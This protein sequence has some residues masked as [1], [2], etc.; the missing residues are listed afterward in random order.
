MTTTRASWKTRREPWA[1]RWSEL[2][3]DATAWAREA[4]DD[5]LQQMAD[6][7]TRPGMTNCWFATYSVAHDILTPVIKAEQHRR[8][9]R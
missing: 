5:E 7:I 1:Q 2:Y 3:N 4:D 9:R 6:D 8:S